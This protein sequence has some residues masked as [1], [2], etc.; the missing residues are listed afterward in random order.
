LPAGLEPLNANLAT[1]ERLSLGEATPATTKGLE[2]LSFQE[3][4]DARVA[5]YADE[6]PAGGYEWVYLAR[7]TTPGRFV[8]PPA[9]AEAMYEPQV[10]GASSI[11]DVVVLPAK[12]VAG[13]RR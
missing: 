4:R 12:Q 1:T 10:N 6:L 2:V 8:R 11:E 3:T 7:A 13:R 5:F 9:S